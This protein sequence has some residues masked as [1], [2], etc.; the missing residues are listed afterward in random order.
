VKPKLTLVVA[1][2]KNGVIGR[3]G[4]LPWR[5]SSDMKRF[6]SITMGK[7]VLMGRKTWE[8]L[9][10]KPLPGRANLVLTRDARYVAE[11]ARVFASLDAM[12]AAARAIAQADGVDEICVIGGGRLYE[13]TLPVADR[14]I[15][16]EV[17]LTPDGDARFP[18]LGAEW[19]EISSEHVTR[20][21]KDDADFVVR[22][23]ERV[24][25]A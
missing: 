13:V 15:L 6:K 16:T 3:D 1:V 21:P 10:K 19:R 8:S 18:A 24:G 17:D 22:V 25:V 12:L 9:P 7:A 23:M 5:L 14:I 20:G 4:D 11:G 2:A